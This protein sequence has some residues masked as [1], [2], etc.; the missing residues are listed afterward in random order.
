MKQLICVFV[1][2]LKNFVQP[3]KKCVVDNYGISLFFEL[4]NFV[5]INPIGL[6]LSGNRKKRASIPHPTHGHSFIAIFIHKFQEKKKMDAQGLPIL[7]GP[8]DH[9]RQGF[10][11]FE[12]AATAQ[13]PIQ[14]M[15]NRS[16]L[17]WNLKLDTVRRTYGSHMAMR[18]A[19]E[20][21][22]MG[23]MRRLPG[24]KSSNIGMETLLGT[25]EQID[26]RD[27]LNGKLW[28]AQQI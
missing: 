8:V 17:E 9:M 2:L 28:E 10:R 26:F 20:R 19:T 4:S 13:H 21:T 22:V 11:S 18:L 25:D 15:Q 12:Q 14:L 5:I 23:R 6:V 3:Q 27:Y 24:L 16:D 7:Q 1:V